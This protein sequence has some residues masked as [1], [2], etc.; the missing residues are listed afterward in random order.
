MSETEDICEDIIQSPSESQNVSGVVKVTRAND[1]DA[2]FFHH[3]QSDDEHRK[4]LMIATVLQV[5]VVKL[6]CRILMKFTH[7]L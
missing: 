7:P 4:K 5:L 2:Y 6:K 1:D 3:L